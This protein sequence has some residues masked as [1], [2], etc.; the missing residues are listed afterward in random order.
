MVGPC[1]TPS[2]SKGKQPVVYSGESDDES[3]STLKEILNESEVYQ[4]TC[5]HTSTITLINYSALARGIDVNEVHPTIA[6][7]QPLTF[8]QKKKPSHTWLGLPK[9]SQAI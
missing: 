5:I 9:N 3:S 8:L 4:C 2:K 7:S 1:A 6:E